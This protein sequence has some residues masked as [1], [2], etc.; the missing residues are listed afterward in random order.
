MIISSVYIRFYIFLSGLHTL[1]LSTVQIELI[2]DQMNDLKRKL[3]EWECLDGRTKL[4]IYRA[5]N[6]VRLKRG[7]VFSPKS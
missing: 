7:S 5:P 1:F 2:H 3:P 6:V 4:T